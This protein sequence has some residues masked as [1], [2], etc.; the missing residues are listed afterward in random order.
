MQ[1]DNIYLPVLVFIATA[2]ISELIHILSPR[3]G[4]YILAGYCIFCLFMPVF[5]L[6]FPV[7]VY[8]TLVIR[9]YPL[10]AVLAVAFA[11]S[12]RTFVSFQ[13]VFT[14]ITVLIAVLLYWRSDTAH[15]LQVMM[16]E[17]RDRAAEANLL[18]AQKN[19]SILQQQ[20]SEIYTATLKERNRI[21]RE[22]HDNVGHALTRA[23]LQIGALKILNHDEN[24]HESIISI[25]DTL[26]GALTSIRSSVHDLHDTTIHLGKQVDACTASLTE[27]F[28]V[29]QEN[30]ISEHTPKS[31]KLC[32][33]GILKESLSNVARH[34]NG[35]TVSVVLREH[36]AFYQLVVRDN[37]T[38]CVKIQESGMGLSGM[39]ER[40]EKAGGIF[41][42]T[43]S[44]EGF[45]IFV[46]IPKR[47][48]EQTE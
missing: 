37:G 17:Q 4:T 1:L 6:T 35:D 43:A 28:T 45:R 23:L 3:Y 16:T 21:A 2:A 13:I 7:F 42:A 18:L 38:G 33:L 5:C 25:Q 24:L 32:L 31:I 30:S 12:V 19:K 36:P 11:V 46:S 44:K 47:N 10:L 48:K 34:S 39:R 40:A 29:H 26:D 9:K 14:L 20:D 41:S 8:D 27:R 15:R 22:I